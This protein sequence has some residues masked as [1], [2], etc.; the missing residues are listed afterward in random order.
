M[1]CLYA[2][3]F[4]RLR[5]RER[6]RCMRRTLPSQQRID[7]E[8]ISTALANGANVAQQVGEHLKRRSD[9]LLFEYSYAV[10]ASVSGTQIVA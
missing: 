2:V 1:I 3:I 5:Q 4:Y 10:S 6:A 7:A 9:R 8:Y